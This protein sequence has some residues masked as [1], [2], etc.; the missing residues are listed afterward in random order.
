[1]VDAKH[2]GYPDGFPLRVASRARLGCL[3]PSTR[4]PQSA[5]SVSITLRGSTLSGCI[6]G[7]PLPN[8]GPRIRGD[9]E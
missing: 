4:G 8:R 9:D 1:M 5:A 2:L 7:S 6:G 3:R